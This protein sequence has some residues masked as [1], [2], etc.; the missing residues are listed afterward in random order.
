VSKIFAVDPDSIGGA[1][2]ADVTTTVTGADVDDLIVLYPPVL[3]AGIVYGGVMSIASGTVTFRLCN[4]T[5]SPI[6]D[7]SKSW[8][9]FWMRRTG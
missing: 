3:D 9:Y 7:T 2:C 8:R 6:D 4:V 5:A 1:T